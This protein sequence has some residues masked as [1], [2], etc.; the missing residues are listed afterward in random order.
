LAFYGLG[1]FYCHRAEIRFWERRTSRPRK[2]LPKADA[3]VV[4]V[5]GYNILRAAPAVGEREQIYW[6]R[7]QT[8][9]EKLPS[10]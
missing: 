6:R 2:S 1:A 8:Q 5:R 10:F 7:I 4:Q 9:L 3:F